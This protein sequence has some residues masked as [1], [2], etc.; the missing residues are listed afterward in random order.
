[1]VVLRDSVNAGISAD[2]LV[3]DGETNETTA[4]RTVSLGDTVAPGQGRR[5]H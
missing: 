5:C 1:M 3:C 4:F 2:A